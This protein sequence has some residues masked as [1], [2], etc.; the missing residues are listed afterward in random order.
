MPG[1]GRSPW[2]DRLGL[3]DVCP[4]CGS[5]EIRL[6]FTPGDTFRRTEVLDGHCPDCTYQWT[7]TRLAARSRRPVPT[8]ERR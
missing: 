3:D 8:R 1:S 4:N 5:V 2:N 7:E 6:A